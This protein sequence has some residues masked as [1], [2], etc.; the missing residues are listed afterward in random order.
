[1]ENNFSFQLL[2]WTF[3][4]NEWFTEDKFLNLYVKSGTLVLHY[5]D[6]ETDTEVKVIVKLVIIKKKI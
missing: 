4:G 3:W 1:M 5:S 2:I 6:E